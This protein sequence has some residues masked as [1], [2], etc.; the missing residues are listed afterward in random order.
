MNGRA[1]ARASANIALV[2]Y[3]GKRDP[4]L[5]LPA[6]GS[7]SVTLAGLTTTTT[8]TI[9]AS[10]GE[11]QLVLNGELADA[12]VLKKAKR[13]LDPLRDRAGAR[14]AFQVS[15][16]N[17]FPTGAGLASSASGLAALAVATA[18]ALG[19]ELDSAELSRVAR[20]G[21]GSACRSLY[22]GY[23]EWLA[24]ERADGV[25]SYAVPRFDADWWDLRVVVAVVAP[26]KKAVSSTDGM[27]HTK[28][29]SPFHEPFLATV[30]GDL[31][32]AKAAVFARDLSA[33]GQ[34]AERSSLRMHAAMQ[35][36]DPA[37]VYLAPES[38]VVISAVRKLQE[39][40]VPVFFTAD[41]GPNIKVFTTPEAQDT[42]RS[43]LIDL[44]VVRRLV[45]ARPGGA[46][47]RIE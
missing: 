33:L 23:V 22:G 20:V 19:L 37:L 41:A 42:V 25:D 34:V 39:A 29:T 10:R 32:A 30:D 47:E 7:F 11:D 16:N 17:D 2:K 40:G 12:G 1:T 24:G 35:G 28:D 26:G 14:A 3:W 13:V 36:A 9:G 5:N 46:A 18:G 8:V 44:P 31:S 15:S 43:A 21:S 4:T 38:W 6:R 27:T 45:A